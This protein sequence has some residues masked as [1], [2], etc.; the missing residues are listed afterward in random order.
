MGALVKLM[1]QAN[2]HSHI[3]AITKGKTIVVPKNWIVYR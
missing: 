2:R 1:V 3:L